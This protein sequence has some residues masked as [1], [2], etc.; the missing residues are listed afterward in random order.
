MLAV[1]VLCSCSL[2]KIGGGT[3]PRNTDKPKPAQESSKTGMVTR[4][5]VRDSKRT[6]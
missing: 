5:T 6:M 1:H 3:R 4:L 2:M